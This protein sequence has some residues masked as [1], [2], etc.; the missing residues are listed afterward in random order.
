MVLFASIHIYWAHCSIRFWET[1]QK[2][3]LK[4]RKKPTQNCLILLN[5]DKLHLLQQQ[6]KYLFN[7][8]V[9]F[10]YTAVCIIILYLQYLNCRE[11]VK[12]T[13]PSSHQPCGQGTAAISRQPDLGFIAIQRANNLLNR[14]TFDCAAIHAEHYR[15]RAEIPFTHALEA[16]CKLL[17]HNQP[18]M[19]QSN[20]LQENYLMV[21]YNNAQQVALRKDFHSLLDSLSKI[22]DS[23]SN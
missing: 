1:V 21:I 2:W 23:G 7:S 11:Q 14:R 6:Q 13:Q 16:F 20:L 8:I 17:C 18:V 19:H 15:E 12:N 4:Q 22:T 5:C 10:I 3:K 9:T